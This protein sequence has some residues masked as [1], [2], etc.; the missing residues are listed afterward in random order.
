M[1]IALIPGSFDPVHNG[2]LAIIEPAARLFAE[3]V[4]AAVK[5]SGKDT[6]F[7][8]EE[9][10]ELLTEAL[11]HLPNVTSRSFSGLSVDLAVEIGATVI[12]K[13]VRTGSDLDSELQQA[14]MNHRM[15][16]VDTLLVPTTSGS[17][18]LSSRYIKDF[19]RNG[20]G[21]QLS[22]VVPEAVARR[23]KEKYV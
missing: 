10:E 12:V 2:H 20:W 13:G 7:S 4:V 3:V 22:S 18:F 1:T 6:L 14:Q 21:V 16:G 23:L 17:S 5:N 8:L 15:S 9:R 11:A 19:A